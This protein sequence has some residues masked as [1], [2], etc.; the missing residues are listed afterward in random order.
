MS[1][2]APHWIGVDENRGG[3]DRK[4]ANWDIFPAFSGFSPVNA[5]NH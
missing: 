2:T 5:V 3:N 4:G 1:K